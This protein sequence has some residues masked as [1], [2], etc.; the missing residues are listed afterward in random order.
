M[1]T[2]KNYVETSITEG[3][4]FGQ[5]KY[6][7][8]VS[9]GLKV[10]IHSLPGFII[11]HFLDEGVFWLKK[12]NI[13]GDY[14]LTYILFQISVWVTMFYLLFQLLPSYANEFQ[15]NIAGIFFV[16]LFFLAQI[17]IITNIK[18]WLGTIDAY[19]ARLPSVFLRSA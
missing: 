18:L 10:A 4:S 6:S 8:I 2:V 19:I 13:L 14:L 16:T 1:N 17:H 12:N 9:F 5:E 15:G 7:T 3:F 11:G